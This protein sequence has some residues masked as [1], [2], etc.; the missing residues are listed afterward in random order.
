MCVWNLLKPLYTYGPRKCDVKLT[1]SSPLPC[2]LEDL[3]I[4][5]ALDLMAKVYDG[6]KRTIP[7]FETPMEKIGIVSL[8]VVRNFAPLSSRFADLASTVER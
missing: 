3:S 4:V 8:L 7:Y 5:Q 2:Y 6:K 1:T